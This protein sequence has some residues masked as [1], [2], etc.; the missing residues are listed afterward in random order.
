VALKP[1]HGVL[2]LDKPPGP[3]SNQALRRIAR[4]IPGVKAGHSGTLDPMASGLLLVL[5]GEATKAAPFLDEEPKVYLAK[6]LL[7]VETDTYDMEGRVLREAA[8]TNDDEAVR[9]AFEGLKGERKQYPPPFS[10]AKVDGVPMYRYARRGLQVEGRTRRVRVHS[11]ELRGT[12][13]KGER[14]EVELLISCSRGTYVRSLCH[15]VGQSLGCGAT[16]TALRR[17]SAGPYRVEEARGLEEWCARLKEGNAEGVLGIVEALAHLPRVEVEGETARRVRN[18][19]PLP[20]PPPV[21]GEPFLV[22]G[23]GGIP[24]AVQIAEGATG[25]RMKVL[26]VFNL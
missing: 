8:V 26:R 14:M 10:A 1:L 23:E 2:L 18:G 17:L 11:V 5:L 4:V 20:A 24:L 25:E 19:S 13:R 6:V 22:T 21:V 12:E 7:G 15:E 3:T 16:L 9:E